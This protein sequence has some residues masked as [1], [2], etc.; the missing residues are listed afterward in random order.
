MSLRDLTRNHST[1]RRRVHCVHAP[2]HRGFIRRCERS[3]SLSSYTSR[4]MWALLRIEVNVLLIYP[5]HIERAI[6]V[7]SSRP[8]P[9]STHLPKY[10]SDKQ[11]HEDPLRSRVHLQNLWREYHSPLEPRER[12]FPPAAHSQA[13]LSPLHHTAYV[14]VLLYKRPPRPPRYHT[15]KFA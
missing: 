4:G 1:D 8:K 3:L 12:N 2:D 13:P 5:A 7:L 14:R 6:H 11:S 10:T 15:T 9:G